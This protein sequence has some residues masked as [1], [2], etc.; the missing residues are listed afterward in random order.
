MNDSKFGKCPPMSVF[1]LNQSRRF[2]DYF[3]Q[4]H[5]ITYI[6]LAFFYNFLLVY[7]TCAEK[8]TSV[9]NCNLKYFFGER[10]RTADFKRD[11]TADFK[12]V[13]NRRLAKIK[14]ADIF[15]A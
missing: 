11:K 2:S 10:D 4:L 12:T 3:F 6:I 9:N 15:I 13:Q 5:F 8:I 1:S 14:I 7:E